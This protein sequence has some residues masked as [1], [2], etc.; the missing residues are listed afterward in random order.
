MAIVREIIGL[1]T[2]YTPLFE[3]SLRVIPDKQLRDISFGEPIGVGKNGAVYSAKWRRPPG[4]LATTKPG[5]EELDVVL[6]DV[7]SRVDTS[8][9][10]Q[11]K[12]FKEVSDV[13][14][15]PGILN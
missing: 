2:G 6:K 11:E 4:H 13:N 10:P 1:E 5:E 3:H 7:F 8:E 14:E 15:I 12:W 9:D